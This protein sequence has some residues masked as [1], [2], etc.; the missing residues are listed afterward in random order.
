MKPA[1][2]ALCLGLAVP[3]AQAAGKWSFGAGIA[4]T[5]APANGV[6]HHLDGAGRRHI[7]V[8]AQTVAVVW[9]DNRSADPQVYVARK[10]GQQKR[11]SPALPVSSGSA[12]FEPAITALPGDRF[13]IAWEQDGALHARV[14]D[15]NGLGAPLK[16]G[17][18]NASHATVASIGERIFAAWRERQGRTWFVRVA[19]LRIADANRL[20][21]ESVTGVES[22]GVQTE[23]LFPAVA[24]NSAGLCIAWE[25]RRAG[26]T[27]LLYSHSP[28]GATDFGDPEHLNEFFSNR[29]QYDQGNGVTRVSMAS[30][31]RDEIVAAWMDKRRGG[32]GYGIFAALGSAGGAVFGP[33][34]KVHGA[35]GDD[36]PHYNPATAGNPAGDFAV[37]WDDFRS[38]DSDIWISTYDED[39]EW[40]PD[41]TAPPAHG[42]GEQSHPAIALDN[43]GALHLLWI[44][45]SEP[46]APSRLWYSVGTP[47]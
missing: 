31:A 35:Q 34:E 8:S 24:V 14:L 13:V 5:D 26:H 4:V 20:Q 3:G 41:F 12:A 37:A 18:E 11:F 36:Q 27:R 6:Y 44:E 38:G 21:V 15:G 32:S 7:A 33:N 47:Q 25:D 30:F 16:L 42:A 17:A 9:E 40:G 1:A 23:V 29:N 28:D 45:R 39:D 22:A 19:A 2:V 43:E 46:N 10:T